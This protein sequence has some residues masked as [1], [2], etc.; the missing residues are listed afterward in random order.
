MEL[1]FPPPDP[2]AGMTPTE[3]KR[4]QETAILEMAYD[5]S[6]LHEVTP[7]ERPDFALVH[8]PNS[9]PFGVEVTQ[10]FANESL[11]RLNLIPGYAIGCGR[12]VCTCTRR[13]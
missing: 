7:C 13:T 5:L 3:R 9:D 10:L 8:T 11:A 4:A 6:R 1:G 2:F 12:A